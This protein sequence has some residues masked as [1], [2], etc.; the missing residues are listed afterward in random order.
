M[1]RIGRMTRIVL[2]KPR[3]E[4]REVRILGHRMPHS[5]PELG[6]VG[7]G[8]YQVSVMPAL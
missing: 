4:E 8:A 2:W 5:C 7:Y 3:Q 1:T 6:M